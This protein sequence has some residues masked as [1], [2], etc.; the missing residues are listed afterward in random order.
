M[1]NYISEQS[2]S[3]LYNDLFEEYQIN[4]IDKFYKKIVDLKYNDNNFS[5]IENNFHIGLKKYSCFLL[6]K[7]GNE[8]LDYDNSFLRTNK[9]IENYLIRIKEKIQYVKKDTKLII[10][11]LLIE[12]IDK[13][14]KLIYKINSE[15]CELSELMTKKEYTYS[16]DN[17]KDI[18]FNKFIYIVIITT[19]ILLLLVVD[20]LSNMGLLID[21][22][23]LDSLALI[24]NLVVK[25][26]GR[27]LI[28]IV[29]VIIGYIIITSKIVQYL[30]KFACF[31]FLKNLT[32]ITKWLFTFI[33]VIYMSIIIDDIYENKFSELIFSE[34]LSLSSYISKKYILKARQ[35]CLRKI[36]VVENNTTQ[37]ILLMGKDTKFIYFVKE[38]TIKTTLSDINNTICVK[39]QK[40]D[41]FSYIDSI[42]NLLNLYTVDKEKSIANQRYQML[43]ISNV[44]FLNELP[45]FELIFCQ[46]NNSTIKINKSLEEE[47]VTPASI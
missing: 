22:I 4:N 46:D 33:I 6:I 42:I 8:I 41:E 18:I 28:V 31:N 29:I 43:Q 21:Y 26:I 11:V 1:N 20:K 23:S 12:H 7:N 39:R 3:I 2:E 24:A 47:Q 30:D 38:K 27:I 45:N 36:K 34:K 10:K 15:F 35:P 13:N 25:D 44:I 17:L 14:N 19:F 16:F 40:D 5:W 32:I 9:G 37:N